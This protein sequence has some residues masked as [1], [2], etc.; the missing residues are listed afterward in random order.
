M[1]KNLYVQEVRRESIDA[2][3]Q[4][5]RA[6]ENMGYTVKAIVL[7]GRPGVRQLFSDIP[8]RCATSTRNRSSPATSRTILN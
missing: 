6:L 2:Y 3:R 8:S 5:R 7:D 4:G 1:K